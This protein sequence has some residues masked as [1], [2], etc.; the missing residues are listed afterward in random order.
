MTR[1]SE[2]ETQANEKLGNSADKAG[3]AFGGLAQKGAKAAQV[4]SA[5]GRLAGE[6]G[7]EMGKVGQEVAKAGGALT[8]L[9]VGMAIG[10]PFALGIAAA[11]AA[12][13]G[14]AQAWKAL[15]FESDLAESEAATLADMLGKKVAAS[16]AKSAAAVA[17]N[18]A[19]ITSIRYAMA[20]GLE[21]QEKKEEL[22]RKE[23]AQWRQTDEAGST[24]IYSEIKGLRAEIKTLE[25]LSRVK[26]LQAFD[27]KGKAEAARAR[28]AAKAQD[29]ADAAED[30]AREKRDLDASL[31]MRLAAN[32]DMEAAAAAEFAVFQDLAQRETEIN[33]EENDKRKRDDEALAQAKQALAQTVISVAGDIATA[34]ASNRAEMTAAEREAAIIQ[35]SIKLAVGLA[36]AIAAGAGVAWPANIAAIASGVAAVGAAFATIASFK[37][38]G[39]VGGGTGGFGG[40]RNAIPIIAHRNELVVPEEDTN[41]LRRLLGMRAGP[42]A[43]SG[44]VVG[45]RG[46]GG[47]NVTVINQQLAPDSTT[48]K[49]IA[50]GIARELAGLRRLGY[51]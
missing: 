9:A 37:K 18:E 28:A 31:A 35:M 14:L 48:H 33:K 41:T 32:Q 25:E 21:L 49:R 15:T 43:A 51:A 1:F 30:L 4:M 11:G 3:V 46:G 36:S 12:V 47:V 13:M 7:G 17:A 16:A 40:D 34:L 42:S 22:L 45:G 29:A 44:G 24:A 20:P 19:A 38:G 5:G 39:I 6:F 27:T 2:A 8:S 50:L 23:E 10:G 26:A